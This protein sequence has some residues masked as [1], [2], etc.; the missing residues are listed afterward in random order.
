M[1]SENSMNPF[2]MKKGQ[3]TW[4]FIIQLFFSQSFNNFSASSVLQSLKNL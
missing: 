4:L 2:E 3:I 1:N